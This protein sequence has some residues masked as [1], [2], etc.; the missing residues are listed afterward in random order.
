MGIQIKG[1]RA[2]GPT[3]KGHGARVETA[4]TET[5]AGRKGDTDKEEGRKGKTRRKEHAWDLGEGATLDLTSR[6]R[7]DGVW[8]DMPAGYPK[9]VNKGEKQYY[10]LRF[11]RFN[12]NIWYDPVVTFNEEFDSEAETSAATFRLASRLA[13]CAGL[14]LA[15]TLM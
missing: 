7:V 1:K 15:C 10:T 12:D 11:P 9:L 3:P 8:T 4:D 6:V 5:G 2:G 14:L 13:T